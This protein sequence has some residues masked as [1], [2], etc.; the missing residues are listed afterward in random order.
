MAFIV[1]AA[2]VLVGAYLFVY[3]LDNI[4]VQ[5]WK[6]IVSLLLCVA[7]IAVGSFTAIIEIL[8]MMG[9]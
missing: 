6:K 9:P 1:A 4:W 2:C 7:C 8:G 3:S 5:G